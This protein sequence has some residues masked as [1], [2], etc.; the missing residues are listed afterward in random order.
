MV[1]NTKSKPKSKGRKVSHAA[2]APPQGRPSSAICR[3][4]HFQR[5]RTRAP[6]YIIRPHLTPLAKGLNINIGKVIADEIQTCARG[7]SNK[8]PL[9]HPSLITHLCEIVVDEPGHLVPPPQQSRAHRR[10]PPP[11]QEPVHEAAPF[12]MWD[13]YLSRLDARLAAEGGRAEASAMDED[14]EDEDD[15]DEEAEEDEDS[16]ND[17]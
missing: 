15:E 6:I 8:A 17:D 4:G 7:A 2:Q 1:R 3:L 10:A 14:I 9:G 13:M 5:N 16:D 11:A 12:Q